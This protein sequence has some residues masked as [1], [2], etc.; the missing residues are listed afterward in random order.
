MGIFLE[1]EDSRGD[2]GLGR[3]VKA[4]P[5]TTSSSITTHTPSGQCNCA[6]RASQLEKSVT[7]L[8]CPGGRTTKSAKDIW[9]HWRKK[10]EN[11][12]YYKICEI[13]ESTF[14]WHHVIRCSDRAD[15]GR[16]DLPRIC[17]GRQSIRDAMT[18]HVTG[19][20]GNMVEVHSGLSNARERLRILSAIW[21]RPLKIFASP[22]IGQKKKFEEYGFV[23]ETCRGMK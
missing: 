22:V 12:Q 15:L 6:S 17:P 23:L 5:G 2:H 19:I 16:G 9:W 14:L 7:L 18:S 3:L 10:H 20:I 13:S 21:S 8:P 11:A 4:P 1:G